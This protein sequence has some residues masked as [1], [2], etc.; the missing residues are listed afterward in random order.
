V[1]A[2]RP[3][4]P[5]KALARL[6]RA[7]Q[8]HLG[9][10]ASR[11]LGTAKLYDKAYE[12][13]SLTET[14][15]HLRGH[16]RGA[17]FRLV[18]AKSVTFR[19]KGGPIDRA[20]WPFI[21]VVQ[22]GSVIAEIWVDIE[23]LALSTTKQK[24]VVSGFPYGKAHELD[25]IVVEPGTFGRPAPE[26]VLIGVEA[27]HRQFNKALLKELLGVRREMTFKSDP[28]PN[29]FAWWAPAGR[30]SANPPSGLVLFCSAP[31]VASYQDP[32]DFWGIRMIHHPF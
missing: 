11:L 10:G 6:R 12:L 16:V 19:G 4:T 23:C 32:A 13:S 9:A 17:T 29:P 15:D 31:N 22:S 8:R 25:I 14:L 5:T 3:L 30:L 7:F 28:K 21:E 26:K 27:K 2:T 24:K 1:T 18:G 20:A